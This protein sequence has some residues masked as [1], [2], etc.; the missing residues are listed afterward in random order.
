MPLNYRTQGTAGWWMIRA[1]NRCQEQLVRWRSAGF[2]GFI[3]LT[4]HDELVFDFPKAKAGAD[5]KPGNLWRMRTL[6]R[7]M[8]RGGEDIG[9]PT[10]VSV[11]HHEKSWAKGVAL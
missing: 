11:E 9:V 3:A 5:G 1:M 6:Q 7:L 10:P 8:E 2:D 4:V